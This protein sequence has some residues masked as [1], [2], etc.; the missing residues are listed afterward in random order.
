FDQSRRTRVLRNIDRLNRG[1]GSYA[2]FAAALEPLLDGN[3]PITVLDI[4]SGHGGF[5]LALS[6][7]REGMDPPLRIIASDLRDEYLEIGRR[8]AAQGGAG[9]VEF[10]VA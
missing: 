2:R 9:N 3:A 8:R 4:A 1:L 5:P 10:L 7:L 6:S